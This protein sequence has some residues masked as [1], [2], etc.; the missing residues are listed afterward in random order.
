MGILQD[1]ICLI[2]GAGS[3]IGEALAYA[4]EREGATVIAADIKPMSADF[5]IRVKL[6]VTNDEACKRVAC[7]VLNTYGWLCCTN[8]VMDGVPLSPG[9]LIP[10]LQ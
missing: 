2:T 7:Q 3:G 9:G 4:A 6:D 5:K 1:E 10:R 8:K